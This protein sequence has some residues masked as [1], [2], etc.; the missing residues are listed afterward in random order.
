MKVNVEDQSGVKKVLHIEVPAEEVTVRNWTG[1]YSQLKKNAKIKGFRPG[2][3]PRSVLERLYGKDVK[4]DVS[5]Q[6][7][8]KGW[9]E[10]LKETELKVLG[11]P[12]VDPPELVPGS[13]YAFDAEVEV[14]PVIDDIDFKGL[15]LNKSKYSVGDEEIDIQLKMIRKNLA[16]RK[17]IEEERP[18]AMEDFVVIDYE[19]F[20]DGQAHK[21][22]AKTENFVTQVGQGQV[23]KDLDEGLVGMRVGEEKDINVTFPDDY[24]NKSLAGQNLVFKVKLNEIREEILPE[25][26]DEM[27]QNV[28][29]QFKTL[30]DLKAA[31][32]ENLENG[33]AKRWNRS[34][35]S[36]YSVR[37][38]KKPTFRSTRGPGA[39]RAGP[40]RP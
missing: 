4:A 31:I 27:A 5:G 24:F 3:A 23:V 13:D 35:T 29:E 30:D 22:T 7:I 21:D 14:E 18:V 34:S 36:R 28:G 10:A 40:Y 8:Q 19:G 32:R 1:A 33:Y 11:S 16:E 12:K 26:N 25:L 39:K 2:K 20:Q 37:F 9:I 38:W 17:T 15:K 6:L